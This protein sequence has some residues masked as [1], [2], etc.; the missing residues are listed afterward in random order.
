MIALML[1]TGGGPLVILT[2]HASA[3]EPSLLEK[4]SAKGIGKFIAYEIPIELAQ[5]RYGGHFKVVVRDLKESDD[6][7]ILDYNGDRAF[8]L[9]HFEECGPPI[10]YESIAEEVA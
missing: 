5:Q 3:T 1:F 9:F 10:M 7:R 6:L 2:S 8:R 4:L